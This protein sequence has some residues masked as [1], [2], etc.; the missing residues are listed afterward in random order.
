MR[1]SHSILQSPR[2][3]RTAVER[4]LRELKQ[5]F[6]NE[7]IT[8]LEYE[9]Q[10]AALL[11]VPVV[12]APT[13]QPLVLDTLLAY[14]ADLRSVLRAAT[15]DEARAIIAPI[16]SHVW[17]KDRGVHAITPTPAFEPLLVGVWKTEVAMGYPTGLV[18]PTCTS[19]I[20]L[21]EALQ[22][23]MLPA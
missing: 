5:R 21:W 17:V 11:A 6:L 8:A 13:E 4:A 20:P 14:L 1:E 19:R 15:R 16:L 12:S 7:V 18:I 2:L 10:R 3:A 9:A 23:R 22:R